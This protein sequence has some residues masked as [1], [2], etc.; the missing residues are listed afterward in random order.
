MSQSARALETILCASAMLAAT[1]AGGRAANAADHPNL[2]PGSWEIS[3][4]ME[5][6]GLP[7]RPPMT[8]TSCIKPEQVKDHESFAESMQKRGSGK[9]KI[10]DLKFESDKLS[11]GFAC[12][13]GGSGSTE[14]SFAGT[15]YEGTTKITVTGRGNAPM[16]MTQ[17][18]KGKRVGD[19]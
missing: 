6:A 7:P 8:T 17:H 9:C 14:L 16:S 1:L 19:C 11:Y 2:Q 4:S 3:I 15:S 18:I 13:G 5:M 10:S 12:E